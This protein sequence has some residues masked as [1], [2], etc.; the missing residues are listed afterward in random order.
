MRAV[1]RNCAALGVQR[2]RWQA[3]G[4][5][6]DQASG[7]ETSTEC[8]AL[9]LHLQRP[10]LPGRLVGASGALAQE[11]LDIEGE[12]S[13]PCARVGVDARA[14]ALASIEGPGHCVVVASRQIAQGDVTPVDPDRAGI[15]RIGRFA[16]QFDRAARLDR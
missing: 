1:A 5:I 16:H 9:V 2:I 15:V 10:V 12:P 14:Q 11:D 4:I 8:S 7:R 6:M 13:G 3:I